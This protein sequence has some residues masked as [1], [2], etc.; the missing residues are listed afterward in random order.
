[1]DGIYFF[2]AKDIQIVVVYYFFDFGFCSGDIFHIGSTSIQTIGYAKPIIDILIVVKDIAKVDYFNEKMKDL[3]YDP[4]GENGISCRRYFTKGKEKRTH[5]VHV[6]QEG[7]GNIEKHLS[8]KAYLIQH[9]DEAKKYGEL[10][11]K[12]A[13]KYPD[14][15][16]KYQKEKEAFVNGI[17][18][19]ALKWSSK[20]ILFKYANHKLYIKFF[21]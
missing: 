4:R 18:E 1:M 7:N 3:G 8:F 11:N 15:T 13:K 2:S 19:K 12:L 6:Y 9:P 21:N 17:V 10:K 16:Y 20:E 5:H 14:D